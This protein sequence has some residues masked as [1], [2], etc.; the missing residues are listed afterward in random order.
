MGLS[1]EAVRVPEEAMR[2]TEEAT[3]LLKVYC[4]M[5]IQ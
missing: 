1:E 5:G 4:S 3:V 2:F